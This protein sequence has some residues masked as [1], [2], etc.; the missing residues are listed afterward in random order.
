M[1]NSLFVSRLKKLK[2]FFILFIFLF[3]NSFII[4]QVD[5]LKIEMVYDDCAPSKIFRLNEKEFIF[6]GWKD[7][8][9]WSL[10]KSNGTTGGTNEF[11]DLD[12][13][14]DVSRN[15]EDFTLMD[16]KVFF[17]AEERVP[18]KESLGKELWVT[19]GT[20]D[21][22]YMVSDIGEGAESSYPSYFKLR[23]GN[24]L[25][26]LATTKD[27]VNGGW[28]TELWSSDGS[29]SG[30]H[31]VKD[32][33]PGPYHSAGGPGI[34]GYTS[35]AVVDGVYYFS[36]KGGGSSFYVENNYL[37]ETNGLE[38]WRSDGTEEGT[39]IV[40]DLTPTFDMVWGYAWSYTHNITK[41]HDGIVFSS[42]GYKNKDFE[43]GEFVGYELWYS[44][45]THNGTKLVADIH[46][47]D[48]SE[49]NSDPSDFIV[50]GGV[51]YFIANDG[52]H[53]RELWI[54]RGADLENPTT[55]MV[56]DLTPGEGSSTI[57]E[58]TMF[59]GILYF[60]FNDGVDK[61]GIEIWRTNGTPEGTFLL[62]DIATGEGNYNHADPRELTVVD[63][64]MYFSAWSPGH[65][66]ELWV[67]DGTKEGTNLV[68]DLTK[69]DWSSKPN[70]LAN[71]NGTLYLNAAE[72]TYDP[73]LWKVVRTNA[74]E[75]KQINE[76]VKFN[77]SQNYPNPFDNFTTI[78]YSV[79]ESSMV[80]LKIYD[81]WG[82]EVSVLVNEVTQLGNYQVK[83]NAN[84]LNSGVY[85]YTLKSKNKSITKKLLIIK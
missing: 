70:S 72:N 75:T 83:L 39:H 77:L 4:S 10:W 53:G 20:K 50:E 46:P 34:K 78:S 37:F 45:G 18:D 23:K 63:N 64:L 7:G 6:Q 5:T 58:Q 84:K 42:Y 33:W 28:E 11:I 12:Y 65:G 3:F 52:V 36:A 61:H 15:Y 80:S 82:K 55:L 54:T 38:L 51:L 76:K 22:T 47:N 16:G 8:S 43:N 73:E 81:I 31:M 13:P 17:R 9:G 24:R 44:D 48:G 62:K 60:V 35:S 27:L 57:T 79:P 30:T 41:Y 74:T 59:K 71:I 49:K 85:F 68:Q 29:E 1:K 66:R 69:D 2:I 26:F 19:D 67:T 14:N 32:I 25:L 56:A 40:T 21:G